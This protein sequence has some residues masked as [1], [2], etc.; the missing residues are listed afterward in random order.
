MSVL[1]GSE[2]VFIRQLWSADCVCI[3]IGVGD[4]ETDGAFAQ[5]NREKIF[6][7][8]Y[9]VQFRH[10]VNFSY[11]YF[12]AKNLPPKLTELIRLCTGTLLLDQAGGFGA[13]TLV[14]IL[15]LNPGY[16]TG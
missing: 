6:F 4:G 11:I 12:E 5:K 2:N 1:C 8:K 13:Q 7:G 14:V 9:H 10:F 15:P 16:T 3:S